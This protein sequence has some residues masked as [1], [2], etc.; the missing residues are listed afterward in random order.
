M[1]SRRSNKLKSDLDEEDVVAEEEQPV[2]TYNDRKPA[3]H[4][5]QLRFDAKVKLS[6]SVT[7][8]L[9]T[10][11]R[12]GAIVEVDEQDVDDLLSKRVG[13]KACCG[14]NIENNTLFVLIEED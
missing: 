8:K 11:E 10:W 2:Y 12:S 13:S 6:G 3:T 4:R 7:G 9:Y 5:L 14:G 1:E